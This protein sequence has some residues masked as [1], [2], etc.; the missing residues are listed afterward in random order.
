MKKNL[1]VRTAIVGLAVMFSAPGVTNAA[2][3]DNASMLIGGVQGSSSSSYTYIGVIAPFEGSRVGEGWFTQGMASWLTYG[4]ESTSLDGRSVDVKGTAPGIEGGIGYSYR[5][6]DFSATSTGLLGYRHIRLHPTPVSDSPQ[7]GIV[8][9]TPQLQLSY[10]LS[11]KV[12]AEVLASHTF[13]Q[14]SQFVRARVDSTVGDGSWR[15]GVESIYL[16]GSEYRITQKGVFATKSLPSGISLTLDVGAAHNTAKEIS[17]YAGIS[18]S[19]AF[20]N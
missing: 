11:K 9:F 6:D 20:E 8:T 5:A 19:K 18:I 3:P 15:A 10:S 1:P 17:I 12:S 4:Y 13:G 7:G 2:G 14:G 16:R